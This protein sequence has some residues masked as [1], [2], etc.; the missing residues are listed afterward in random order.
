MR[1]CQARN[2]D[3]EICSGAIDAVRISQPAEYVQRTH[4]AFRAGHRRSHRERQPDF[5]RKRKAEIRWHDTNDRGWR[6]VDV[7]RAAKD[8]PVTPIPALP[9]PVP[10][11][12]HRR[13]ACPVVV[14]NEISAESRLDS[15]KPE[16]TSRDVRA[17]HTFWGIL[18]TTEVDGSTCVSRK[19]GE[20][21]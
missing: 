20:G 8:R 17:L 14:S 10:E 12:D 9:Q 7:N 4:V 19:T 5:I 3:L 15:Q 1:D 6:V 11:K 13:R 21:M 16:S 2:D 18:T